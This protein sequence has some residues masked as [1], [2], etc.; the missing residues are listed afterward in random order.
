[1]YYRLYPYNRVSQRKENVIKTIIR[2]KNTLTVLIEKNLH[3]SGPA[4]FKPI[5][6]GSTLLQKSEK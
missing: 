2:M 6:Q 3:V 1:M 4:Q 5:V